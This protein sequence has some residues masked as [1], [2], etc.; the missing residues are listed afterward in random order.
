[1]VESVGSL[2][3]VDGRDEE[4]GSAPSSDSLNHLHQPS[5]PLL[6]RIFDY[7]SVQY[8]HSEVGRLS[9]SLGTE[10]FGDGE[11]MRMRVVGFQE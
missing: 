8:R 10:G 3:E 6:R 11:E 7:Y 4:D 5:A 2:A 1:M 9:L